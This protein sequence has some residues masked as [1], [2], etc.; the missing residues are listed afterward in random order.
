M[1]LVGGGGGGGV[2][3]GGSRPV[4]ESVRKKDRHFL[5]WMCYLSSALVERE[6]RKLPVGCA[7][8]NTNT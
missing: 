1:A 3:G 6:L 8:I 2:G 5:V 7:Y 4:L